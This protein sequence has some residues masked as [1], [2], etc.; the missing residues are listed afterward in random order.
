MAGISLKA[1]RTSTVDTGMAANYYT[2]LRQSPSMCVAGADQNRYDDYG[3]R[4]NNPL[5]IRPYN[6]TECS[7]YVLTT[8][9]VINRENNERGY[10]TI[11]KPGARGAGDFLG[12]KRDRAVNNLYGNS[13]D[14]GFK[15]DYFSGNN[16][17]PSQSYPM[18]RNNMYTSNMDLNNLNTDYSVINRLK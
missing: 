18:V 4:V 10:V 13:Q 12:V 3:R 6:A 2:A 14:N 15:R 17:G 11:Q 8:G 16:A 9:D 1:I 5:A 7:P